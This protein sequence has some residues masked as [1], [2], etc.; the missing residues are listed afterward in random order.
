MGVPDI[1]FC[2]LCGAPSAQRVPP[3]EDRERAMCTACG[4]LDYVNPINVVGTVP[5]WWDAIEGPRILLCRRN[6]EPR[7]GYWTLPAGFLEIGE[8]S[9]EGAARET[10]EEAGA[11]VEIE[12]LF[13]VIDLMFSGQLHV[14]YR[15]R[16]LDLDLA[17]GPETIE[18]ALVRP[19][20]IP[21]ADL[22]FRTVQRTLEFWVADHERGEYPVHHDELPP[23]PPEPATQP[24]AP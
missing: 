7:K 9:S 24:P 19:D 8:S 14:Y 10:L 23:P 5:V 4:Y 15:A 21:W 3:M 13:S 17:P 1:R 6:I 2:R 20:E 12:G 22:A 16:L 11:R 18:N